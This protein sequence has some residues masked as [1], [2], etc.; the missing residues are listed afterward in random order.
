M[1]KSIARVPG[2]S[3]KRYPTGKASW[4]Y[5]YRNP[6][7]RDGRGYGKIKRLTLGR[8]SESDPDGLVRLGA[9][10]DFNGAK[11]LAETARHLVRQGIDPAP[12]MERQSHEMLAEL[13]GIRFD[14][15]T[16]ETVFREYLEHYP[17]RQARQRT[18]DGVAGLLG[19]RRN[20]DGDWE[21]TGRGVL[22]HWGG[23]LFSDHEQNAK[24]TPADAE[25]LINGL[26]P[27]SGNR[28]IT[29]L[30]AIGR[31]S[32]GRFIDRSPF[33]K[34]RKQRELPRERV[35][36]DDEIAALWQIVHTSNDDTVQMYGKRA[37]MILLT[38]QRPG[39]VTQAKWAEF[40][41]GIWYR[42]EHTR[43]R[44][45]RGE[46]KVPLSTA[47]Q[48]LLDGLPKRGDWV[49]TMTGDNP[50]PINHRIKKRIDGLLAAKLERS[51]EAWTYHDLRRTAATHMVSPPLKVPP[52]VVDAI[53][54]H[55]PPKITG[56]YQR[57]D[58]HEE[59]TA[60]LEAW[61]QRVL[62]LTKGG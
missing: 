59:K 47:V 17:N 56:V 33:A 10:L 28:T 8:A 16:V 58:W 61:G 1:E 21:K 44:R 53:L 14:G 25:K 39:E 35:L 3:L 36:E 26:P 19:L 43:K 37:L 15:V 50:L 62:E 30:K 6:S 38:G 52:H 12:V 55:A 40:R 34:L 11:H 41:N 20:A 2:L 57:Y 32:E 46:F 23:R 60:A 9:I 7:E 4:F 49:F 31:W 13:T 18:V 54:D 42:P 29:V 22:G 45:V 5:R 24:L 51:P 48:A 27:V